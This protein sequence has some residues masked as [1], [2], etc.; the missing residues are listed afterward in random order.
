MAAAAAPDSLRPLCAPN[1]APRCQD[2][3]VF[4]QRYMALHSQQ[5][6]IRRRL[7]NSSSPPASP[8]SL[9][10]SSPTMSASDVSSTD[11][12]PTLGGRQSFSQMSPP[13]FALPKPATTPTMRKSNSRSPSMSPIPEDGTLDVPEA[14]H[15]VSFSPDEDRLFGVNHDIKSTLTDLLNCEAVRNDSRMR[16]WVQ[17]RLMD[18]ELELKRQRRRRVSTPAIVLSPSDGGDERRVSV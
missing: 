14:Y 7:S 5:S 9:A 4:L 15:A 3:A 16:M 6:K 13:T 8:K 12:S 10:T 17:T 1:A 18:A 11:S 2:K